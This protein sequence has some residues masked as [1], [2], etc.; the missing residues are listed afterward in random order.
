MIDK[1]PE[2]TMSQ[3]ARTCKNSIRYAT[4]TDPSFRQWQRDNIKDTLCDTTFNIDA[5]RY[6]QSLGGPVTPVETRK[7][8]K[9]ADRGGVLIIQLVQWETSKGTRRSAHWPLKWSNP[10]PLRQ[11]LELDAT[12]ISTHDSWRHVY[13]SPLMIHMKSG[14]CGSVAWTQCLQ[15]AHWLL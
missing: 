7:R 3:V 8:A 14:S 9:A 4:R 6:F 11:W 13:M 5:M 2:S 10:T 15:L 12:S 1:D